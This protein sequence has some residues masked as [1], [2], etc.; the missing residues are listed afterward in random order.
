[1]HEQFLSSV[2]SSVVWEVESSGVRSIC[3]SGRYWVGALWLRMRSS[4]QA[5][6]T[7]E[8][9]VTYNRVEKK[10]KQN[11]ELRNSELIIINTKNNNVRHRAFR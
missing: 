2:V 7:S 5:R 1:M 10:M 3:V 8:L 11:D 4:Q 9:I 6:R